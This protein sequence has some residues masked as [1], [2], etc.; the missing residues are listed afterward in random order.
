MPRQQSIRD[1]Q[2]VLVAT[3]VD[4]QVGVPRAEV[5]FT[6]AKRPYS[7]GSRAAGLSPTSK[8][9][10]P[11]SSLVL[12]PGFGHEFVDEI[13]FGS[14]FEGDRIRHPH[15]SANAN[16][17]TRGVGAVDAR[18]AGVDSEFAGEGNVAWLRGV[19]SA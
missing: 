5:R 9:K 10:N 8:A 11:K 14:A 7:G 15:N 2:A 4:G 13:W 3:C 1:V 16:S 12:R 17:R 19:E 18:A 6:S